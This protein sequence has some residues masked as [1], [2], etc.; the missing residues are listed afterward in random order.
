MFLA[1]IPLLILLAVWSGNKVYDIKGPWRTIQGLDGYLY[2]LS[3]K[4]LM[5]V[6]LDGELIRKFNLENDFGIAEPVADMFV[7][8]DNTILLGLRDS[9]IIMHYE[10]EGKEISALP[11]TPS[12]PR[13]GAEPYF[14]F[15]VNPTDNSTVVSDSFQGRLIFFSSLG[16]EYLILKDPS[17]T[18][19][20]S[21]EAPA[22]MNVFNA[23][24]LKPN[25]LDPKTPFNWPNRVI[26]HED[27]FFIAD[28]NNHRIVEL[29]P[30]GTLGRIIPTSGDNAEIYIQPI[31]F[32][33]RDDAVYIINKNTVL[34]KGW[35]FFVDL[36]EDNPKAIRFVK[37]QSPEGIWLDPESMEPQ[38]ILALESGIIVADPEAF[39]IQRFT[40]DG[41]YE[42]TFGKPSFTS[43][44][45]A[46][47]SKRFI[48]NILRWGS[49]ALSIFLIIILKQYN[50]GMSLKSAISKKTHFEEEGF[51]FK[52]IRTDPETRD[53]LN[54]LETRKLRAQQI[55]SIKKRDK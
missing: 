39:K 53:F 29:M 3:D 9:N 43:V 44:L 46:T 30:D 14:R 45:D 13:D 28:T 31:T 25:R 12:T 4:D 27:R 18:V 22:P 40:P 23:M 5:R 41:K 42:G 16:S 33:I 15:A 24:Q 55:P 20:P 35:L 36:K 17:G 19:D 47:K 50:D 49:F 48:L 2:V 34:E 7:N 38:D 21:S 51:E 10:S 6:S 32:S 8:S 52:L 37:G 26:W 11:I 1:P 54:W